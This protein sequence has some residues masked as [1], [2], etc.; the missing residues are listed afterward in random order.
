MQMVRNAVTF[1]VFVRH[2]LALY[3]RR[4][5]PPQFSVIVAVLGGLLY[6]S[7]G[8]LCLDSSQQCAQPGAPSRPDQK[9]HDRQAPEADRAG[10]TKE[11]TSLVPAGTFLRSLFLCRA[12][13]AL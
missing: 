1:L 12:E 5:G 3:G 10:G 13:R 4:V 11:N 6:A 2:R 9:S 8:A 7:N